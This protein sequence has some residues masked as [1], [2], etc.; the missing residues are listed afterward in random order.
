[1]SPEPAKSPT[2]FSEDTREAVPACRRAVVDGG[3]KRGAERSKMGRLK[4]GRWMVSD[5]PES[6]G[7][8]RLVRSPCQSDRRRRRLVSCRR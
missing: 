4:M 2:G 7:V 5:L 3:L 6:V 1:M 8:S